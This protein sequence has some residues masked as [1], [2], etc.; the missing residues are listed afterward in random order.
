MSNIFA[1]MIHLIILLGLGKFFR[2]TGVF[3]TSTINDIKEFIINISLPCLLF[4]SFMT[5][6][7]KNE[8]FLLFLLVILMEII[9]LTA[10]IIV[11]RFKLLSHPLVL[12]IS[13][14]CA[15]G[16]IGIPFFLAVYD[17]QHLG[18]FTL[19]SVGH[20]IYLWILLCSFLQ[21]VF[22]KQRPSL[23]ESL[24]T[25][26]SPIIIGVMSGILLNKLNIDT[27]LA[28][29]VI[30]KGIFSTI[31]S[32]SSLTTPLILIVL[33]YNISFNLNYIKD[34]LKLILIRMSIIFSTGYFFKYTVIDKLIS[35]DPVFNH[36]FFTF[37]VTPP[38]LVMP[39]IVSKY[40]SEE[41][42]EL[43]SNVITLNI[44]ASM[45]IY[46]SA[47]FYYKATI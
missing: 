31:E 6:E 4:S 2:I 43:A 5:M 44:I 42:S 37:L 12:F 18:K 25:L 19:F 17:V 35:T 32:L 14:G 26:I 11:N 9:F 16:F 23:K 22:K 47:V 21:F 13:T 39:I 1:K 8:H 15:A 29:N 28:S 30:Y 45:I 34:S 46:M 10:A 3:K 33:G 36:A 40:L 20:E 41:Y 24:K 7:I 27:L 38:A